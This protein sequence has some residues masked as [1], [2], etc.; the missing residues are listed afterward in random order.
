MH[1]KLEHLLRQR[2]LLRDFVSRDLQA[3]YVGSTGG[4]AW[5]VV[6]P[7]LLLLVYTF[8]F[9]VILQVRFGTSGSVAA[10]ALYLYCGLLPWHAFSDAAAR[11]TSC[12]V[13]HRGLIKNTRFPAKVLPVTVVL[14]DV[15]SEG[16]GLG[17]LVVAAWLFGHPPAWALVLLPVLVA[18]Q[19]MFTLGVALA[20]ATV[21]VY[22]RDVEQFVRVG[23]MLWMFLTPIFYPQ[24]RIPERLRFLLDWN[25]MAWLVR[26]YRAVLLDGQAFA[27]RDVA[28]YGG[29]AAA[30]LALGYALFTRNHRDF[31]DLL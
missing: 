3:K 17:F 23:L 2:H 20:L 9:S 11:S 1:P 24:E 26:M 5:A 30:S 31:A 21:N 10:F 13:G 25:P 16:I 6:H 19:I 4:I 28:L 29:A 7:L 8:V 27:L 22:F 18:L 15:V 14:T 12:L